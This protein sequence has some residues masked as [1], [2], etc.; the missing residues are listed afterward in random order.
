MI[1]ANLYV[2]FLIRH[3]EKNFYYTHESYLKRLIASPANYFSAIYINPC[4]LLLRQF[5]GRSPSKLPR[6]VGF[7]RVQPEF[8][9]P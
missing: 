2:M 5:V 4:R 9:P 7:P 8:F 6:V 3:F 1:C